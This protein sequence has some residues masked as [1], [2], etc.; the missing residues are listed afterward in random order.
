FTL[1]FR[2]IHFGR[3][4]RDAEDDR[5]SPLFLGNE[6]FIRGYNLRSFTAEECSDSPGEGCSEFNRLFGSRL[7]IA[8]AELR[9]P[10]LGL[11]ELA[12]FRSRAFPSTL[13]AFFDG[14]LAWTD[15]RSPDLRWTTDE[16]SDNIPVFST[17]LSLRVNILGYLITEFYY[18]IPFQRPDQGGYFGFQIAPGW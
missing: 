6:R 18:A 11:E 10:V 4:S 9:L 14:G 8:N 16:T 15:N 7:A 5:L 13:T 17:G 2:A 3:Y 12:L 1:G